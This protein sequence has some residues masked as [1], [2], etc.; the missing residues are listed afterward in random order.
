MAWDSRYWE[1]VPLYP[2]L[3]QCPYKIKTKWKLRA[4]VAGP[5]LR[6]A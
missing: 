5:F 6:M 4:G 1:Q 2:V 3:Q